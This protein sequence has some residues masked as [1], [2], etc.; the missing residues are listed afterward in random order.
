MIQKEKHSFGYYDGDVIISRIILERSKG[1][2]LS[3]KVSI[4]T[5]GGIGIGKAIALAFARQGSTVVIA[6]RNQANLEATVREIEAMGGKGLAIVADLSRE[7][8]IKNIVTQTSEKFGKIDILVNNSGIEGRTANVMEIDLEDWNYT[9]AVNL[10]G[11]MLCC[12][13][14]VKHMVPRRSGNIINISSRAGKKALPFRGPYVV[15]KWGLIGFTQMLALEL[16]SYN[17]RA[18]CICPSVTEGERVDRVLR[19]RAQAMNMPLEELIQQ[20]ISQIALKRMT[21]PE[22]VAAAAVFLV[23]D[24]SSAITGQAINVDA[25]FI[26]H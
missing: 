23:S 14:V 9:I 7:S 4:V 20:T 5:G 2:K 13:E 21:K 25:G 3:G 26:M 24:E 15:T 18:N 19:L 16:G 22:E 12:R 1:M 17:I 6:S 8:D 11:T 10:T